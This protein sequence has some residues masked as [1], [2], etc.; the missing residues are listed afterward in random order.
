MAVGSYWFLNWILHRFTGGFSV[1][2]FKWPWEGVQRS[3]HRLH[4]NAWL[5]PRV[6]WGC[7]LSSEKT[8]IIFLRKQNR[9]KG[10]ILQPGSRPNRSTNSSV[11]FWNIIDLNNCCFIS[12]FLWITHFTWITPY[13]GAH[14]NCSHRNWLFLDNYM[15]SLHQVQLVLWCY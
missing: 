3:E 15:P 1:S 6:L 10:V 11:R 7:S 9:K 12:L 2:N 14:S 8:I 5:T 4:D 13:L